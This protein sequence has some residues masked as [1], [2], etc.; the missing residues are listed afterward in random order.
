MKKTIV[1]L[2]LLFIMGCILLIS[3]CMS[4]KESTNSNIQVGEWNDLDFVNHWSNIAFT[5][6][7]D[8]T[9]RH[10][11]ELDSIPGQTDDFFLSHI[12]KTASIALM[13]IDLLHDRIDQTP[14]EYLNITI[15]QLAGS[16]NKT[17]M[18]NAE[19]KSVLIADEEYIVAS[20]EF[21]FKDRPRETGNH[22]DGY[23]RKFDDALIVFLT[24]YSD[25][26]KDS[27]ESF[28]FSIETPER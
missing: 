20:S 11:E 25:N 13:Y 2:K 19:F 4:Q 7:L 21:I 27:V 6:P 24:V 9:V 8:Y 15:S 22:Q 14:E 28:L 23:V 10:L 5:L 18:F 17:Y 26:K 16:A 12:D 3:G 1:I